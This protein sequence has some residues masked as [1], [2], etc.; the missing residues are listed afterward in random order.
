MLSLLLVRLV[1]FF[2]QLTS[3]CVCRRVSLPP[4]FRGSLCLVQL[5]KMIQTGKAIN[6][7]VCLRCIRR[8]RL[9]CGNAACDAAQHKQR[10]DAW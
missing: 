10:L 4:A 2:L 5:E 6:P 3:V 1:S 7:P 9:R 8:Q